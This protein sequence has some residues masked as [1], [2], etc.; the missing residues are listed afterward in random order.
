[1]LLGSQIFID[2]YTRLSITGRMHIARPSSRLKFLPTLYTIASG[3]RTKLA[4]PTLVLHPVATP[5]VYS[6]PPFH[7]IAPV[8]PI[9]IPQIPNSNAKRSKTH[10]KPMDVRRVRLLSRLALVTF[11][12]L[13]TAI[14]RGQ[15]LLEL[16]LLIKQLQSVPVV[17]ATSKGCQRKQHSHHR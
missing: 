1:M 6:T 10:R 2:L 16:Q 12:I 17:S 8:Q 14:I 13:N 7:S 3:R 11:G 5:A 15:L 4:T 9:H